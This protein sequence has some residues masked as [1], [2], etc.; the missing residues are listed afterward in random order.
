MRKRDPVKHKEKRQ[1]ILDAAKR[2]FIRDG[3]R[4]AS[5]SDICAEA[6]ISAGHLYHY[7]SSK[8]QIVSAIV[9]ARLEQATARVEKMTRE[10]N[11]I[12][13]LTD[14]FDRAKAGKDVV[15][16][17][18]FLL[19]VLAEATRNPA[20]GEIVSALSG[21]VRGLLSD[22]LRE[23]QAR[24]QVDPTLDPEFAA[25]VLIGIIDGSL[26]LKIRNPSLDTTKATALFKLLITRFLTPPQR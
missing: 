26:T 21:K 23:A 17:Q 22:F 7:F 13:A 16:H 6:G 10:A 19:D 20:I 11:A 8:E 4:G 5:I 1:D 18:V 24:G 14:A 2:C 25:A 3:L 15:A 12:T 9:E